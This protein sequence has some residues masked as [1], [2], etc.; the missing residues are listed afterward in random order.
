MN[1]TT[2][3]RRGHIDNLMMT[4]KKKTEKMNL[5]QMVLHSRSLKLNLITSCCY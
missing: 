4:L 3:S 1:R 5:Y 2:Q